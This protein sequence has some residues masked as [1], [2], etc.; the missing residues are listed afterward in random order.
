MTS[1]LKILV[2]RS[3]S[4]PP[5][6][7]SRLVTELLSDPALK[8]EWLRDVKVMA[9]RIIG[10]RAALKSNLEKEGSSRNWQHIVDQIGMFCYTGMDQKQVER[11]IK[12]HSVYLT[13]DGR[14]SVAGITSSNVGHL[15]KAMHD[16]T[17]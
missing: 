5:I 7:G 2:R 8:A 11:I 13:K 16:V 6:N 12:E 4:S 14:I 15:A 9:D 10:M 3:Y 1:Q 17:K